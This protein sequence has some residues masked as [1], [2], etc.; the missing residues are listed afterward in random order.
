MQQRLRRFISDRTRIFA[1]MSHDLK[2]PITRLRLRTELLD[3]DDLRAKFEKDLEEMEAMVAA[4][5]RLHARRRNAASRRSRS[6]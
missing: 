2:T 5:A 3:D 4:D 1:A 6:T